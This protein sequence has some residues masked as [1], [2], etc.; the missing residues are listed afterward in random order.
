MGRGERRNKTKISSFKGKGAKGVSATNKKYVQSLQ[1]SQRVEDA[2]R[3]LCHVVKSDSS[4]SNKESSRSNSQGWLN[5]TPHCPPAPPL[6][7]FDCN[8]FDW[9]VAWPN[10][11]RKQ[12]LRM[13]LDRAEQGREG[14]K[15]V[16]TTNKDTYKDVSKASES[17]MPGGSSVRS[18]DP[19]NLKV[20][21]E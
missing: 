16:S 15:D 4:E 19:I 14:V 21:K 20:N 17:K 6:D 1:Q 12:L 2:G 18:F 11:T 13:Q 9:K 8:S 3:Q 10:Q 5:L 7:S